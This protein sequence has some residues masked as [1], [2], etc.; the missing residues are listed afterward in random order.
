MFPKCI[1]EANLVFVL[2][3]VMLPDPLEVGTVVVSFQS[4]VI[5]NFQL[6]FFEKVLSKTFEKNPFH[7][8]SIDNR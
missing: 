2:A 8:I 4:F 5:A 7:E 6:P 1:T 3:G